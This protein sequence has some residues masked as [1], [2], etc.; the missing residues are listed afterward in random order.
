MGI[1]PQRIQVQHN[2]STT[3][4]EVTD[5]VNTLGADDYLIVV[6]SEVHM[7]RVMQLF[8]RAGLNRIPAPC[9]YRFAQ[10]PYVTLKWGD[11]MPSSTRVK[12][13]DQWAKE[14]MAYHMGSFCKQSNQS[15]SIP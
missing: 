8:R 3:C 4:E 6:T 9:D 10:N 5:I 7:R 15:L 14:V 1:S 2:P 11:F 12:L 13:L